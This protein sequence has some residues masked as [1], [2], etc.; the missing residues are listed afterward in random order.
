MDLE[1]QNTE[2]LA[3]LPLQIPVSCM[4]ILIKA[5]PTSPSST[6]VSSVYE[7]FQCPICMSTITEASI[8]TCGHRFCYKCI[9]ECI[10]RRH[11]CPCCKRALNKGDIVSDHS[12]DALMSKQLRLLLPERWNV[13]ILLPQKL[14]TMKGR[15][16]KE[17]TIK[18]WLKQVN[19]CA[20]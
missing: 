2:D 11:Q 18:N 15:K 4:L 3:D 8:T 9:E 19:L 5:P 14:F 16:Q 12:F 13:L 20:T 6:Q 7:H 10:N 17:S 1:R